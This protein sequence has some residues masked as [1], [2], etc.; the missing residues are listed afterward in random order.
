M[1]QQHKTC[2]I[3]PSR[4][5]LRDTFAAA[6]LAGIL[7]KDD[8]AQL[9]KMAPWWPEWACSAA[10][11]WADAMIRE[12]EKSRAGQHGNSAANC[13][14]RDR[15]AEP[16]PKEKR[17]EVSFAPVFSDKTI[18]RPVSYEKSDDNRVLYDTNHD[19]APA[20]IAE[21]SE[22]G[23]RREGQGTGDICE[24][25]RG[26]FKAVDAVPATDLMDEAADEIERLR[27]GAVSACETVEQEPVAWAIQFDGEDIDVRSVFSDRESACRH[28]ANYA[29]KNQI[30]PLYR[31]QQPALATLQTL[32]NGEIVPLYRAPT[33]TDEGRAAIMASH[34]FWALEDSPHAATLRALLERLK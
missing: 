11:R 4:V 7:T 19:A 31:H 12:R 10:Y 3:S 6:A 15:V 22:R 34:G 14:A 27:N 26:W 21:P 18:S 30:V 8:A 1:T 28:V 17:A 23:T 5:D 29:G 32:A 25:L 2:D 16:L 24:R 20:A 13:P 9:E 33:L